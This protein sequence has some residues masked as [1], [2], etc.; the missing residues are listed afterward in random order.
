MTTERD[1]VICVS[2]SEQEWQAFV[3]RHPQ[4]VDW[5]RQQILDQL[6]ERQPADRVGGATAGAQAATVR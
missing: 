6:Q 4:P 1:R 2:L 5:I 3:A